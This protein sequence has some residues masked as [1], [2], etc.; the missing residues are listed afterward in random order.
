MV[1]ILLIVMAACCSPS[2]RMHCRLCSLCKWSAIAI[3]LV[4]NSSNSDMLPHGI[5]PL[6]MLGSTVLFLDAHEPY[7]LYLWIRRQLNKKRWLA[8]IMFLPVQQLR[9]T[10]YIFRIAHALQNFDLLYFTTPRYV[11]RK[12]PPAVAGTSS[13]AKGKEPPSHIQ[14]IYTQQTF[15]NRLGILCLLATWA[16][17]SIV[18]PTT[19]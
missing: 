10:A 6:A 3:A 1:V 9:L 13:D 14:N 12:A 5:F 11:E 19:R 8:K 15:Y 18:I 17:A 16:S 7:M 2:R 4:F